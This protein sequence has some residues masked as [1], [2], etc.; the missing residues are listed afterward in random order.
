[1]ALATLLA[2]ILFLLGSGA[3]AFAQDHQDWKFTHPKP[4]PNL[5]RKLQTLDANNWI[6]V[7]ANGTF[8]RTTDGGVSWYFHHQAGLPVNNALQ[9][10]ANADVRFVSPTNGIIVG[11]LGFV[12]R[13][14]DGGVTVTPVASGVPTNQAC[15]S[16]SFGDANTGYVA[17]GAASGSS[18]TIIKTTDGG[19]SWTTVFTTTN[20]VMALVAINPIVVHAVLQNGGVVNTTDGGLTWSTPVPGTVGN[21]TLGMSFLDSMTGFVVGSLGVI[22][23]TTDGGATWASLPPP[24]TDWGFF[25][26][27]IISAAE[28][29]AVGAPDFL[30]KSTDLGST[31]T[32]LPIIP[33]QGTSGPLDTLVFYS[34]EKQGSLMIM[35]GDFGLIA[36]STNGGLSWTSNN[37]QLTT[38]GMF[39]IK[40]VPNT[41]TVV[42]VGRQRTIGT[43]QVLRSTNLGNTWSAIDLGVNTDLQGVSFVDSQLG[44]AC[45]TNSQV[46]KTTDAGLTWAPVTRPSATN[47]TLQAM[48]FVDANTGWIIVNFA[49]VP[50]GNIFKTI[51]GGTT[52]TQQ[53]IGTTDS[54]AALDMVDANVGYITLNSSGRPIYKTTNGG[55]NWT[56]VTTPFTAQIRAVHAVD[57]NLVY[58]GMNSGT[59]RIGKS[60]DGGTT[61]QQIAL[62]A[63]ADVISLDFID[64]NTGYVTG[65]SQNALF[66]TTDGGATWSFQ[67]AHVIAVLKIYAGPSGR[68]WA[69]GTAASILREE[70]PSPTPTPTASPT[71]TATATAS[72]TPTATATATA[73]PTPTATATST[74][75]AT[76]TP[77]P[78]PTPTTPPGG[79]PVRVTATLGNTGPSDYPT[80]R[81]AF[82]A[83][84]AG[85]HQGAITASVIA[86]TTRGDHSCHSE[87]QWRRTGV[88]HVGV[89]PACQ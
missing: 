45:G 62:P 7:G 35:S 41:S 20:P 68:G 4:Q 50:G 88:V 83:I 80:L 38:A 2:G 56:P 18:G 66:K 89:N 76:P 87:W 11:D 81:D 73:T 60:I 44:Y 15:R 14:S 67:N 49:T 59:N 21:P 34:L 1:M 12:G 17:A 27:K 30:Y 24:Q 42:A 26:M 28:I 61:W 43:R 58:I 40:E 37:F 29:Y 36:Q 5:L 54:L 65:Q 72:P 53:T 23:K 78:T 33:V 86:S 8:M 71:P 31:W 63:A 39:D 52:W 22:S 13:T 85:V 46:L 84:N 32:P 57:A 69:L 64:A 48:E 55:T 10:G 3:T 16:I 77:T 74:A 75:T 47:Y 51:D 70:L 9:I 79:G 6:A 19:A 82:N 25:Q